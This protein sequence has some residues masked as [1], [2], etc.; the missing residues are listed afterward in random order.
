MLRI[1]AAALVA[2]T[3]TV[4]GSAMTRPTRLQCEYL[5]DPLG[6]DAASP[7]LSWQ[8]HSDQRGAAQTAYHIRV[9]S[10]GFTKDSA[11]KVLWDSGKVASAES[12]G[13]PYAGAALQSEMRCLWQVRTW[14]Q[15]GK[16][17]PWT[18]TASW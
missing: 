13:I 7:L 2:L 16:V 8:L 4:Q 9:I 11:A 18:G 1:L 15:D 17:S 5:K 14:D 3:L 6:L 10:K 12:T